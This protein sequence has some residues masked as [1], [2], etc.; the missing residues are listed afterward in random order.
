MRF[1]RIRLLGLLFPLILASTGSAHAVP[2]QWTIESGGNGHWYDFIGRGLNGDPTSYTWETAR[3]D[4]S[5]KGGY[6]ATI[7]SHAE[8]SFLQANMYDWVGPVDPHYN[9]CAACGYRSYQGFLGGFQEPGSSEP[10]GGWGWITGEP[11][12]FTAWSGGEPNNSPNGEDYLLTWFHNSSGWNDANILS[13]TR[14]YIEYDTNPIPEPSTA[15]LLGL[16]LLGLCA[17]RP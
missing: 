5:S 16:G 11:W 3:I 17:R 15:I 13:S 7:T 14:Y 2:V 9:T 1:L 10:G 4:A 12:S 8:W 6:L